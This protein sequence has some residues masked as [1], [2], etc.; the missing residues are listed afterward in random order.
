MVRS[1]FSALLLACFAPVVDAW[2]QPAAPEAP[3]PA[4]AVAPAADGTVVEAKIG[5]KL[6]DYLS[7][8]EAF[9]FN[10]AVMYAKKDRVFLRKAYG[11]ASRAENRENTLDTLFD[12]ASVTKQFT[13]AGILK[14]KM[15]GKLQTEDPITKFFP[16]LGKDKDG[17][18]LYHLMTHTAGLSPID[19]ARETKDRDE[20]IELVREATTEADAGTKFEYNNVNF[21]LLGAVIEVVSGQKYEA[22]MHEEIFKPAG[23]EDVRFLGE[24]IPKG[25]RVAMAH[26]GDWEMWSAQEAWFSWAIRGAA[27]ALCSVND[28]YKWE[29]ALRDEKVLSKEAKLE[30][31]NRFVPGYTYGWRVREDREQKRTVFFHDGNTTGFQARFERCPK[32]GSVVIVLINDSGKIG[33]VTNGLTALIEGYG[34]QMPPKP[35]PMTEEKLEEF[36]GEYEMDGGGKLKLTAEDGALV[37][38]E[39]GL[40]ATKWRLGARSEADLKRGPRYDKRADEAMEGWQAGDLQALEDLLPD[41]RQPMAATFAFEWQ[42]LAEAGGGIKRVDVLGTLPRTLQELH[43]F[44]TIVSERRKD[45]IKLSWFDGELMGWDHT[46]PG[47]MRFVPVGENEFISYEIT[48]EMTPR[49]R[50]MK[51]VLD[52][53]GKPEKIAI[54]ID[55]E[56]QFGT[57]RK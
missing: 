31:F 7:R 10:G 18:L 43:T 19:V 57:P 35:F 50:A 8:L 6:D 1:L 21:C 34:L 23:M 37:L 27:G 41:G 55:F 17:I 56:R 52:E 15:Q 54:L 39:Y 32:D 25:T 53:Q 14:L 3:A 26:Q 20:L 45:V 5:E 51:F 40:A 16:E 22:F 49:D 48:A 12:V 44:V 47:V 42:T 46:Y 11:Y 2:G 36:T 38:R 13:S 29:L 33:P 9:G 28:L 4:P 24:T 30:L